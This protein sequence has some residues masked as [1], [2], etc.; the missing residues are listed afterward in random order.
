M[1]HYTALIWLPEIVD[2]RQ[3]RLGE[4]PVD[5][6]L[7]YDQVPKGV[8]LTTNPS[9]ETNIRIWAEV[10]IVDKTDVRLTVSVPENELVTFRQFREKFNVREKYLKFLCP[11]E[12][13]SKWFYVYRPISLEEIVKFE[14]KEPNG[15]YKELTPAELNSLCIQIKQERD[16]AIDFKIITDGR[17]KGAKALRQ[18]EGVSPSWL[19]SKQ[20]G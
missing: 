14:R 20:E 8:N 11:Y 5:P 12:E 1:F 10:R 16:R 6:E 19:L 13:R 2:A 15:K 4:L 3:I 7:S 18:R 9:P 17:L